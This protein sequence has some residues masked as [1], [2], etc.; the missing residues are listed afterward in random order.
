MCVDMWRNQICQTFHW[1]AVGNIIYNNYNMLGWFIWCRI[2][3]SRWYWRPD[4]LSF[5]KCHVISH[6]GWS[7]SFS[8]FTSDVHIWS[9]TLLTRYACLCVIDLKQKRHMKT[10]RKEFQLLFFINMRSYIFHYMIPNSLDIIDSRLL[11][12][13]MHIAHIHKDMSRCLMLQGGVIRITINYL[14]AAAEKRLHHS[15]TTAYVNFW[16]YDV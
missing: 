6:R 15:S 3:S 1:F 8:T 11:P 12:V 7:S 9:S 5:R 10:K 13:A 2:Q 4:V 14:Y 16:F